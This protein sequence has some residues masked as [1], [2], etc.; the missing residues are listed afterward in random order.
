[1]PS[2]EVLKALAVTVELTGGEI[3]Q[4]AARVLADD[5]EGYPDE[6]VLGALKR[7]RLD[8]VKVTVGNIIARL[9]DGRPGV[10][11]AW[12]MLPR[13]EE[14]SCAM[15]D[16]IAEAMGIAAPLIA[17]G[18]TVAARMA[19]K[20]AYA[21]ACARAREAKRP[22]KWFLSLGSDAAGREAAAIE[23]VRKGRLQIEHAIQY[24]PFERQAAALTAMGATHHPLLAA[25]PAGQARVAQEMTRLNYGN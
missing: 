7:I 19:F 1:M 2:V 22:A 24:V 3:S 25:N 9:D 14:G 23:A 12:A 6:Q 11:E 18:D 4:A 17:E 20:E 21:A 5:L 15:T 16:E 8:G 10:E 13:G